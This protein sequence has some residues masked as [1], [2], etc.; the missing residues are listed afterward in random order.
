[1]IINNTITPPKNCRAVTIKSPTNL[2]VFFLAFCESAAALD[3]S[4][5]SEILGSV[6]SGRYLGFSSY[7]KKFTFSGSLS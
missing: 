6:I 3:L 4:L 1:M 5:F 7:S 2:S